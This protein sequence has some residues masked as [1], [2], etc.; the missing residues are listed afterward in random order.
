MWSAQHLIELCQ[1]QLVNVI[2]MQLSIL[3][4]YNASDSAVFVGIIFI[5]R[6]GNYFK[7]VGFVSQIWGF[8][9]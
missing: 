5:M 1:H 9:T 8:R 2:D 3:K 7:T 6:T 4:L